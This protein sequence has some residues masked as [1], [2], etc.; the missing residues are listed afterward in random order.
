[1]KVHQ[2]LHG[3]NQG[4]NLLYSS[5]NLP[6]EDE[7]YMKKQS[8]WTEYVDDDED[9]SYIKAYVLPK[10]HLYV[11]SKSWYAYEMSRPGCVWT[12]SL[13]INLDDITIDFDF[14]SL[15]NYFSR[16]KEKMDSYDEI[17]DIVSSEKDIA[18]HALDFFTLNEIAYLYFSLLT[19]KRSSFQ[20]EEKSYTY[21]YLLLSL[22]QFLPLDVVADSNLC[23]G[24]TIIANAN[25]DINISFSNNI[26]QR[27]HD[28]TLEGVSFSKSE[29]IGLLY[30]SN[31][32]KIQENKVASVLRA[33]SNE[34]G[35]KTERLLIFGN[36]L[37]G[38]EKPN[39]ITYNSILE[40]LVYAFPDKNDGVR[41]KQAFLSQ[42]VI[43][44]YTSMDKFYTDLCV[45]SYEKSIDIL[46][47]HPYEEVDKSIKTDI[48]TLEA[49]LNHILSSDMISTYGNGLL[50]YEAQN[51]SI[52]WQKNLYER[53]WNL[54]Q[55]LLNFDP[56][57][58]YNKYWLEGSQS[59][60]DT[61]LTVFER[62]ELSKFSDW[63]LLL[64]ILLKSNRIQVSAIIKNALIKYHPNAVVDV[65]QYIQNGNHPTDLCYTICESKKQ[66]MVQWIKEQVSFS[67][68]V[69]AFITRIMPP[70]SREAKDC[71]SLPWY[72]ITTQMAGTSDAWIYTY[73]YQLSFNWT[74]STAIKILKTS[75]W[76]IYQM[77][78]N[79]SMC[80]SNMI[81]L[82]SYLEEL[83]PWQW[84]DNCKKLR[85][86]LVKTMKKKGYNRQDL[87]NFTPSE[88]LNKTLLKLWD[89]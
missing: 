4:H 12:H 60:I 17:L 45:N 14:R 75:F 9:S 52:E 10:S 65:L 30:F 77:F 87:K 35:V 59:K 1:M 89:K 83:P 84:W 85:K 41:I 86:G 50:K 82:S 20:I 70:N 7:D 5:I 46:S 73:L 71:G 51:L 21:Q 63:Q 32:I 42:R 57:W 18:P 28:V 3:Y 58:L 6:Y 43:E 16:P 25:S 27:L 47:L 49:F 39:D 19:N 34:I 11:I 44:L 64:S 67:N 66:F 22:L 76:Q 79:N 40:N 15:L 23:S 33:Y 62:L 61:L 55:S 48:D 72:K 53:N 69:V 38:L 2:A 56:S 31:A 78:E 24:T 80:K 37:F 68:G 29:K 26:N 8:D 13:I 54:F 88:D 74:D 36:L 81:S